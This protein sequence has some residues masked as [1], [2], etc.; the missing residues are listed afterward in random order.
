MFTKED[1]T[2]NDLRENSLVAWLSDMEKHEDLAVRGGVK[3]CREYLQFLKEE[4]K[5]LYDEN[6][7]KNEYLKKMAKK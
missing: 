7:L 6:Q 1:T 4:N 5:R 3:L 2:F